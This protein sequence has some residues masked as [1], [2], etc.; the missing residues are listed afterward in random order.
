MQPGTDPPAPIPSLD[1]IQAIANLQDPARRNLR[2]TLCYHQLALPLAQR[3]G[4][5]ANWCAFACWASRQAGETIRKQDLQL[6]VEQRLKQAPAIRQTAANLALDASQLDRLLLGMGYATALERASQAVGRGNLKVFAEIGK[7]FARFYRQCL[8]DPA[9]D[10]EHIAGFCEGLTPGDPPD[11]Q[12]Y[13]RRAFTHYYR[14][15]FEPDAELCAQWVLLANLEVGFH[16][17]TRLQPEIAES[18][19]AGFDNA[20]RLSGRGLRVLLPS[21]G[22]RRISSFFLRRFLG[23]PS[24]SDQALSAMGETARKLA[25]RELTEH[26]MR[27]NLPGETLELGKD[28]RGSYPPALQTI[29]L[30]ELEDLLRK[31][32]PTPGSPRASGAFDWADL[33]ERLHFILELFRGYQED[34]RLL[35]PPFT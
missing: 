14:A 1:E 31:L 12:A 2:I 8:N 5:S 24:L 18:L 23:R 28:L 33:S 6:L 30:P 32:D 25:R 3:T 27:L 10:A 7:E 26:M 20:A 4:N 29:H 21:L 16:E 35:E 22:W 34:R 15:L 19:E 17:Q 11:G 9:P 13:L